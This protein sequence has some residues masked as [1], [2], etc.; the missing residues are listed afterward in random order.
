MSAAEA[1]AGGLHG[2]NASAAAATS[3][4][5][6]KTAAT[7]SLDDRFTSTRLLPSPP[8]VGEDTADSG[9]LPRLQSLAHADSGKQ[10]QGAKD[11]RP[12]CHVMAHKSFLP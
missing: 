8:E 4:D 7:S 1:C 9:F 2:S 3:P 11:V 10:L 6:T 12:T 5:Q